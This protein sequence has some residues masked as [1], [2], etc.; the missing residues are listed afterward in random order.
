MGANTQDSG[1]STIGGIHFPDITDLF[2]HHPTRPTP[3]IG[4]PGDTPVPTGTLSGYAK[5]FAGGAFC[6]TLT[7]VSLFTQLSMLNVG[8]DD[9]D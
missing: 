5:Y 4:K 6:C 8:H 1:G 7:H 3:R 9:S 2:R